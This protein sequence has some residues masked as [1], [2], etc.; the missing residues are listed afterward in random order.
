MG[1]T[2]DARER[3]LSSAMQRIHARSYYAVTVDDICAAA[4]V[5]KGSFYYYFPSKQ[6]LVVAAIEAQ[7]DRIRTTLL[8][9]AFAPD[10]APLARIVRLFRLAADV[11][12]ARFD[13]GGQVLG[14]AFGNLALELGTQDPV[15]MAALRDVFAGYCGYFAD[16]LAEAQASGAVQVADIGATARALLAFFE[17]ALLL[18]KTDNDAQV[19]S[20]LAPQA[21]ALIG[22][23]PIAPAGRARENEVMQ[24]DHAVFP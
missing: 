11:H 6:A 10:L 2:S 16:A 3:L 4:A 5:N 19:I 9:P 22:C 21:L 1:R 20:R 23:P 8:E 17:G 7:W 12:Q 13:T 24:D 14:C 15:V 18:A